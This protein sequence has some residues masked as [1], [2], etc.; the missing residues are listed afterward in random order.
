MVQQVVQGDR[1]L[2]LLELNE[3]NFDFVR[4]YIARGELPTLSRLIADHG[5]SETTSETEYEHLEPW[6]QWI[7]AHTG[8]PFAEHGVFRLGDIVEHDFDQ[9]W[10]MLERAGLSV[11]AI[12]PMNA[13][14]RTRAAAFFVPDP[15]TRTPVTGDRSLHLLS[16]ALAQAVSEN[17][18]SRIEAGSYLKLLR[19]LAAHFRVS[20]FGELTKLA[21]GKRFSPWYGAM[22]LDRM[23]ADV[24]VRQ[25]RRHR[26]NF[27]SLF[28][29]AAA[30]IQHHYMF[31]SAVY[32]GPNKNPEWYLAKGKDPLLDI[33][34]VYDDIVKDMLALPG[35][36]RVMVATG[37]HQDPYPT[38]LYYYRLTDHAAFLARLGIAF[39]TVVPL[40]SRDFTVTF[41]TDEAC[42]RAGESL[43]AVASPDGVPLFSVD[44]RGRTLFVMLT[45]PKEIRSGF[46][47]TRAG[48][49]LWDISG[50]VAFV[51]LKNGE[52]N[53]IGYYLDTG[54]KSGSNV[55]RFRLAELPERVTAALRVDRSLA[56][57]A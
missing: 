11:G 38:E 2:I 13:K 47:P 42:A 23:L 37:L 30:H 45:Y 40:M 25:W 50:D 17:A 48:N 28:L 53:G 55:A 1:S 19:G 54:E 8:R 52:H 27:A 51:A 32:D 39:E 33:Y 56:R 21:L 29:N 4:R 36:P 49:V 46:V 22:F 34:R 15:W 14:N 43:S 20:T 44:N 5:L 6:I 41:A 31:S 16:Q 9:I 24:F 3:V 35:S 57:V 26:P 12:S 18:S 7:T 10:E